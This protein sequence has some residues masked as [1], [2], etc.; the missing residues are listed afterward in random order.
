MFREM[1]KRA[2]DY[3]QN[4]SDFM[5]EVM[6]ELEVH[7]S[8]YKNSLFTAMLIFCT[9]VLSP[10]QTKLWLLIEW[11]QFIVIRNYNCFFLQLLFYYSDAYSK[12]ALVKLMYSYTHTIFFLMTFLSM[13]KMHSSLCCWTECDHFWLKHISIYDILSHFVLL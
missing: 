8:E 1:I 4:P 6:Q 13:W 7:I 3:K 12:S 5:D 10:S 9:G 11:Q 2:V